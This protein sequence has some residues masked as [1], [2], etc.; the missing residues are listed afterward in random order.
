MLANMRYYCL[1]CGLLELLIGWNLSLAEYEINLFFLPLV[2]SVH[3]ISCVGRS[4]S[5][6]VVY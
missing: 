5:V 2:V 6:A 4:I 3:L 1:S